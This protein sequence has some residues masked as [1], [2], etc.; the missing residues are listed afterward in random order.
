MPAVLLYEML[1]GLLKNYICDLI[2][3]EVIIKRHEVCMESQSEYPHKRTGN[4]TKIWKSVEDATQVVL[5]RF[6]KYNN[7]CIFYPK[8]KTQQQLQVH[9][10]GSGNLKIS[11]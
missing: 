3:V 6:Q 1:L 10:V 4:S 11:S 2:Y 9:K 5:S 8:A 7:R